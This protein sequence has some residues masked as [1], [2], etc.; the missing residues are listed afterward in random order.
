MA[1]KGPLPE[2]LHYLQP[3][4]EFLAK[5]PK[6]EIGDTA[7][8][9]LLE[10]LLR[11]RLHGLR[12][13]DAQEKLNGDLHELEEYLSDRPTDRLHF[14]AGF[15]LI[16]AEKPEELLKPPVEEKKRE[17]RLMMELPPRAKSMSDEHELAVKW[18]RQRFYALQCNIEDDFSQRSILMQFEH[19]NASEYERLKML[20]ISLP[21]VRPDVQPK[22][23]P[24]IPIDLGKVTGHK[25]ITSGDSPTV[26]KRA[27]Y[28]LQIPGAYVLV[29][30]S[31]NHMFDETEWDIY[32][33]TLRYA[34]PL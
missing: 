29:T 32:L 34:I 18:K 33:A 8:T 3:F 5:I 10:K 14:V 23:P 28:L 1:K 25:H 11:D 17:E 21:H 15:L 9:S 7:D 24:A 13:K 22:R 2:R 4:H 16:A 20:G 31:A 26:W 6:S 19:P 30:I 12:A 27:D